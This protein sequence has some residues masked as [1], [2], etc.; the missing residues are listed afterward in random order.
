M[1][2]NPDARRNETQPYKTVGPLELE[3]DV[4]IPD[5]ANPPALLWIHGGALITGH[6]NNLS[7]WQR[8]A[9]IDAGYAVVSIDYRLAPETK[10]PGIVEDLRDAW[11]WL[12]CDASDKYGFDVD[13]TAVVG[14]SAGGYLTLMSGI[15][16]DPKPRALVAFYGYGDILGDWYR[17]PDPYYCKQPAVSR[18]DAYAQVGGDPVANPQ[19]GSDRGQFYLY[20]RQNGLWPQ[21]VVGAD[22]DRHP[23][24]F[25]P[26]CPALNV[27]RD[28][29][30]TM[31]LHGTAD[32]DVPYSQSVMMREALSDPGV[33]HEL[34][35]IEGGAHGFDGAGMADP[36]VRDAFGRVLAF[37]QRHVRDADPSS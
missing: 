25:R 22:P 1:S 23:E 9:Y 37:L 33:A 21:V 27:T 14:H 31:L 24:T 30:P 17:L 13:R 5:R 2:H 36:G 20:C 26:F 6:R 10:L 15:S 11:S 28:F 19:A 29:P 4:Y 3:A 32:T 34:V 16:L 8:D 12:L 7:A 18:D 35:T